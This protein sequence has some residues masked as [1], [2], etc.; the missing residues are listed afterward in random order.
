MLIVQQSSVTKWT[1]IL[2]FIHLW[3]LGL[4]TKSLIRCSFCVLKPYRFLMEKYILLFV[5]VGTQLKA[6]LI[7]QF[8]HPPDVENIFGPVYAL[9]LN[10]VFKK[11]K[12]RFNKRTSSA[13]WDEPLM[14]KPSSLKFWITLTNVFEWPCVFRP[15][16]DWSMEICHRP[17][18]QIVY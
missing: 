18:I 3:R 13:V 12:P 11:K 9:D 14:P 15:I 10:D 1:W 2:E 7:A 5:F 17:P 16:Y 6:L 8:T 4:L